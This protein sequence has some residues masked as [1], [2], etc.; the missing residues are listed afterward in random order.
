MDFETLKTIADEREQVNRTYEI[1]NEDQ[2]LASR[3]AHVEFLTTTRTI[4]QY[5]RPGAKMLDLGAGAGAYSLY[6]A[7]KGYCVDA[8]ELADNNVRAFRAKLT[9]DLPV[10]LRQGTALDL[11]AYADKSFD[12]VLVMG[13]LYHLHSAA[14][15]QTCIREAMRVCRDDGVLFFAFINHDMVFMSELGY[16]PRYFSNGDFDPE[17]MRLNDFPFVFF[18][19]DECRA[20]LRKA[21][22]AIEREIAV[23]GASELMAERINGMDDTAYERYLKYHYM[24]CEKPEQ[25]GFSNHLLFVGRKA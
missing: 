18:T 11:S 4:E 2:R 25:L 23:D 1:F 5:L 20:M 9:D 17:T 19:L 10:R 22:I 24:M 6:F 12:A 16:N 13:P 8:V 15:R 7:R 14:D 21:G 3:A